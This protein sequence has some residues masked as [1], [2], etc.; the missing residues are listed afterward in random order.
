[1]INLGTTS[2]A[3]NRPQVLLRAARA[4]IVDY[5]RRRSLRRLIGAEAM[6]TPAEAISRLSKLEAETDDRRR[7][8]ARTYS[9]L[10]HVE[11][12]IAL[13]GEARLARN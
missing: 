5:D 3:T 6:P 2:P 4:G 13:M 1:M 11:L 10:R 9:I 7:T 12:L 8:G